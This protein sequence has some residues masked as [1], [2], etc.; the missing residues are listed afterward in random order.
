MVGAAPCGRPKD[1]E[2]RAGTGA[3]PYEEGLIRKRGNYG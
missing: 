1:V 2:N 3:C